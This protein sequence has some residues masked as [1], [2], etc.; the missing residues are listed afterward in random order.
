M[1]GFSSC[2][3]S[4]RTQAQTL[5]HWG[6]LNGT[7]H[8]PDQGSNRVF[9]LADRFLPLSHQEALGVLADSL[10]PSHRLSMVLQIS[11][12]PLAPAGGL[13]VFWDLRAACVSTMRAITALHVGPE[14]SRPRAA[15]YAQHATSHGACLFAVWS[16]PGQGQ[17]RGAK[18][19]EGG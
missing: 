14:S 1:W 16:R 7:W 13:G 5:W 8:L 12:L 3:L 4:S 17:A 11:Q 9:A 19:K 15:S 6:F 18:S 2:G 10:L